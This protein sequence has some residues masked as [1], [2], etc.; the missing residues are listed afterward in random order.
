MQ[1][2]S[3]ASCIEGSTWRRERT[4]IKVSG[5]C[6]A[7][8]VVTILEQGRPGGPGPGPGPGY[9]PGRPDRTGVIDCQSRNYQQNR[10][11]ADGAIRSVENVRQTSSTRCVEG[12]NY[13]IDYRSGTV[14]VDRGCSVRV[15]VTY[16]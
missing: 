2:I 1:Q 9:P 11:Q 4:G 8:F 10:C 16:W 12:D 6:R 5:G 7:N 14:W 3:K 13:R 15:S